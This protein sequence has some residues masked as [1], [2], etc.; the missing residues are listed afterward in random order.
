MFLVSNTFVNASVSE[1]TSRRVT[2]GLTGLTREVLGRATR[3]ANSADFTSAYKEVQQ[4]FVFFLLPS[5]LNETFLID[6]KQILALTGWHELS[7]TDKPLS[8][9]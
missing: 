4:L 5:Q 3:R 1:D 8:L 6:C 7:P 9:P 2:A